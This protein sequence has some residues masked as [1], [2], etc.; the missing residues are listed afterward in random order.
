[1]S[2]V[3]KRPKVFYG[4][5]IVTASTLLM[6]YVPGVINQ[7]FTAIFQPIVDEFGW[8]YAQVSFGAMLRGLECGLLAP[9]VGYLVD[10]F[11]PRKV[12]FAG[13]FI[14]ALG[15][16]SLS[17]INSL[18]GFYGS[19]VLI[20]VGMSGS[21][22]TVFLT[23]AS[24]W[25]DKK[26]GLAIG[27]IGAGAGFSGFLVPV[28]TFLVDTYDW[29][30]ALFILSIS[31]IV[32]GVPAALLLRHKP[33]QYGCLPDGAVSTTSDS[34]IKPAT[35]DGTRTMVLTTGQVLKTRVFWQLGLASTLIAVV[36]SSVMTH[37]MPYMSSVGIS[38]TFSSM[39]VLV[40]SL[41]SM[42]GR[43]SSGWLGDR[44]NTKRVYIYFLLMMVLG[45]VTFAYIIPGRTGVLILFV[46]LYGVGAAGNMTLRPVL[47]RKYFHS[48]KFGTI[49]GIAD[50]MMMLGQAG[51]PVAGWAFDTWGSYHGIWLVFSVVIIL[52]IVMVI[53]T[54]DPLKMRIPGT[55][56]ITH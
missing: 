50:M 38:R 4:W 14:T 34:R 56:P 47:L 23:T 49:L 32:V 22:G 17:R 12:V 29:R 30:R 1:M 40:M 2:P 53:T 51:V 8:S 20:A 44:F 11:G 5:W 10:R 37:I 15:L 13:T 27:L 26:I 18:G 41:V 28:I 35:S 43:L 24:Y 19:F 6:F 33:E 45:T 36:T 7:G 48:G 3:T 31:V 54:P 9:L 46:I 25:F 16:F 21:V 42:G 39:V 55:K 52:G